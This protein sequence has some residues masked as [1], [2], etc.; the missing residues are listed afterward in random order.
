M[1]QMYSN[2]AYQGQQAQ[3]E[4]MYITREEFNQYRRFQDMQA[5]SIFIQIEQLKN[6][7]RR[8]VP[9][10]DIPKQRR[11]ALDRIVTKMNQ[12]INFLESEVKN[13]KKIN[14]QPGK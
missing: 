2:N 3:T 14:G 12:K 5:Q 8:V 6:Y 4:D 11:E 10:K 13:L 9:M 1:N 7:I